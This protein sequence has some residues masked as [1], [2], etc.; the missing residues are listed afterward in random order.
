M[1]RRRVA[2]VGRVV[3]G[4]GRFALLRVTILGRPIEVAG[5]LIESGPASGVAIVIAW[6]VRSGR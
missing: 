3:I 2:L 1:L 5:R 4:F 6:P